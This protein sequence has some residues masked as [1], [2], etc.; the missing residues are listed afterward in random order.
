MSSEGKIQSFINVVNEETRDK[1]IQLD[2][3]LRI[4]RAEVESQLASIALYRGND[5]EGHKEGLLHMQS[6]LNAAIE[7]ISALV[8]L[9]VMPGH[10][11]LPIFSGEVIDEF[12]EM[13]SSS[14]KG[15][16]EL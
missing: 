12:T 9:A 2:K 4:M 5:P 15:F 16:S 8:N 7:S 13:L 1:I 11:N 6:E 3:K 14:L 10:E